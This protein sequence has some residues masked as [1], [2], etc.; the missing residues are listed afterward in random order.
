MTIT[1]PDPT[2]DTTADVTAPSTRSSRTRDA[3]RAARSNR[4][5]RRVGFALLAIGAAV[6]L[7]AL[8]HHGRDTDSQEFGVGNDKDAETVHGQDVDADV[9]Y[10]VTWKN[11][12]G[13]GVVHEQVFTNIDHGWDL[14]QDM[15]KSA[16]A[17]AA[18]WEH[19]HGDR[20]W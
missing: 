4:H 19:V 2:D 13:S 20:S 5:V 1:P 6:G 10:R 3:F 14:Y 8:R 15:K 9:T 7:V 11:V 18:T 12:D 17:Y 16:N